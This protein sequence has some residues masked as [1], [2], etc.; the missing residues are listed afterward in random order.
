M[1]KRATIFA[2]SAALFAP[3]LAGCNVLTGI[4]D[5]LREPP[6]PVQVRYLQPNIDG[7]LLRCAGAPA[8]DPATVETDLDL[9]GVTYGYR[10]AWR[11]CSRKLDKVRQLLQPDPLG[12]PGGGLAG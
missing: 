7:S 9:L 5:Q 12:P 1:L 4:K 3:A 11:D 2:L 6:P 8:V 10:D